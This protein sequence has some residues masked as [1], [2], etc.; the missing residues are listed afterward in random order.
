MIYQS[1]RMTLNGVMDVFRGPV[2]DVVI[3]EEVKEGRTSYY[4]LLL[5]KD[6]ETVRRLIRILEQSEKGASC[7]VDRFTW[8]NCFCLVFGYVKARPLSEFFMG[9]ERSLEECENICINLVLQC[10]TSPLP[11]PLLELAI[12][13]QIHLLKDGDVMLGYELDLRDLDENCTERRC[14]MECAVV[15][16]D[17]L[18]EKLS[19]KNVSYQLLMKKI[20]RQSYQSF[21]DLYRDI[22]LSSTL[23]RKRS[24][25][26]RILA[27][28]REKQTAIF[29]CLL[30][31]SVCLLVLTIIMMISQRIWGEVPFLRIFF[32]NFKQ[33]GTESLIR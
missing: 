17:L 1:E 2:N 4:T 28:Y 7:V 21:R 11:W 8:N 15:V 24:I 12:R 20:P 13:Q 31:V 6:H 18:K 5:V 29:R 27:L 3:C 19:K 26:S 14:V 30:V 23:V 9:K 32:N 22:R 25:K 16:R 33:I 10:M